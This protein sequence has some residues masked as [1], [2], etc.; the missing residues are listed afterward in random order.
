[1]ISLVVAYAKNQVIGR[2][3]ELPWY[4]PD[5]LK[6]FKQLTINKTV[7]M[8]R[9]TYESIVRRLGKGLPNRRNIVVSGSLK[10]PVDGIEVAAS[11]EAAITLAQDDEEIV[12]IGGQRI[13]EE[14]ISK[15]LVERIYATEIDA[16]IDGDTFFPKLDQKNWREIDREHKNGDSLAYDFVIYERIKQ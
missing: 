5:D 9:N 6:H 2:N 10:G 11:L 4:I 3:N 16:V 15:G 8:G 7:V 14:A 13:F 1:M 12:L